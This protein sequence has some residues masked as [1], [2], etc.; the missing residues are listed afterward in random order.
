[1][2]LW[3]EL[4]SIPYAEAHA[5][6]ERCVAARCAGLLPDLVLSCEH[7]AVLTAGRG[8]DPASTR[9]LPAPLVVVERGGDLTWHGP[10]QLVAYPIRW[11]PP[12]ERDLHQVLRGLEEVVLAV[13][14]DHGVAGHRV[15]D[16]TGVWAGEHKL[17]SIGIAVRR[18]VT[19]HGLALNLD[20]P[21]AVWEGF[22]PCG[23][24]PQVMSDLR[25]LRGGAPLL[26][27]E[28]APHLRAAFER[29]WGRSFALA[30]RDDLERRLGEAALEPMAPIRSA[31]DNLRAPKD[32]AGEA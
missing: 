10:G 32:P 30:S 21:A 22:Q 14:A 19:W 26:R 15:P 23:L 25:T 29:L 20:V 11:L 4:D 18:W 17:C 13:L 27:R 1:M 6:Q 5:L 8:T 12:G 31:S 28:V 7:P 9:D 24:M 2:P 3:V 16:K